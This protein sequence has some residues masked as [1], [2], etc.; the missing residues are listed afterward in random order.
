MNSMTGYPMQSLKTR[1]DNTR[2]DRATSLR[3]Q[4]DRDTT[5]STGTRVLVHAGNTNHDL[6]TGHDKLVHAS[7]T[8]I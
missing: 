3:K 1:H 7:G 6:V 8:G 4:H 2:H 5:T